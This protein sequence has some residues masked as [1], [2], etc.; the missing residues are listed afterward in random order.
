MSIL[1]NKRYFW[2]VVAILLGIASVIPLTASAEA[3]KVVVQDQNGNAIPEA[4]VQIGNQ[5]QTTDDSGNAMFS[6]V[7]GAQSLT[8][9]AIGFSSKR[10]N[11]TAGQ[12][13][14]TVVLAPIQTVDAVVVVGTRSIGRRALAGTRADRSRQQRAA[15]PYRS[16]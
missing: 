12:T 4:K 2:C 9:I 1:D 11:T 5:E 15:E 3:L 10:L 8:V 16:I 7:T 13:E 6:D 14:V